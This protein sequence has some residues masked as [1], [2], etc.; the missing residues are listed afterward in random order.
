MT[1]TIYIALL[2][3]AF[4]LGFLIGISF[5]TAK[6][7]QKVLTESS[8]ISNDGFSISNKEYRNFLTYDGSVQK[9]V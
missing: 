5:P 4:I 3:W 2:L 7:P 9:G 6:N 1:T 8:V